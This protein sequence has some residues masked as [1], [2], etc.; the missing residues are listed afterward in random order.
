MRKVLIQFTIALLLFG[1][2]LF[3]FSQVDWLTVFHLRET[4]IED[5]LGELYWK[6]YSS[7]EDFIEED[8]ILL[9]LDSLLTHLCEANDLNRSKIKLHAVISEEVNAFAFPDDHLVMNSALILECKNEME[10]CGIIAHEI[11]HIEQGHVMKKLI[12]EVGLSTLLGMVSGSSGAELISKTAKLLSSTAY[13]RTLESEADQYAVTYLITAGVDPSF[14]GDFLYRLS[15][16]ESLPSFV[17]WV[18]THPESEKRSAQILNQM[19]E[20]GE[21]V[22]YKPILAPSTWEKLQF[23]I[24]G[25]FQPRYQ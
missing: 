10:L 15:Q 20:A 16:K 3:S 13:D 2:V 21:E 5:K 25:K 23:S 9:P 11:A 24:K 17:E 14:L 18:S 19:E 6:F 7:T 1:T 22:E 4:V 12:K 8:S